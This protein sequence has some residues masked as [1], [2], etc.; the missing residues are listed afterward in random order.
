[1]KQLKDYRK[2]PQRITLAVTIVILL[3]LSIPTFNELKTAFDVISKR[4]QK[5]ISTL[6][7]L[8]A[9]KEDEL[10]VLR[11]EYLENSGFGYYQNDKE[12]ETYSLASIDR[13][14]IIV[15]QQT[16]NENATYFDSPTSIL[17]RKDNSSI[18]RE[19]LE[20]IVE[21][22]AEYFELTYDVAQMYFDTSTYKY[23][24][25]IGQPYFFVTYFF[26]AVLVLGGAL[27]FFLNKS[28]TKLLLKH[29][30]VEEYEQLTSEI[31]TPILEDRQYIIT[32]HYFIAKGSFSIK[33]QFVKL[34]DIGW[35][36]LLVHRTRYYGIQVSKT[37]NL[38]LYKN[39][40]K[41]SI[42]TAMSEDS[43]RMIVSYLGESGYNAM[44]GYH[45]SFPKIWKQTLNA[46]D[47][48]E[49]LNTQD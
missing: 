44:L 21:D 46:T 23:V 32:E 28:R 9:V 2:K 3:G 26:A 37:H 17:V 49:R 31:Q 19:A 14:Y 45:D 7:E 33:K 34:S 42:N 43:V 15:A 8:D 20:M 13:K 1:M 29:F 24:G 38:V 11:T 41:K 25:T 10:I 35:A 5:V 6:Y 30:T 16:S 18:Y 12:I 4:N 39:G 22:Y 40:S 47:F 27:Y 48:K 36:Y